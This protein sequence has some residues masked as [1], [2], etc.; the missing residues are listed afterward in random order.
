MKTSGNIT[1]R[2]PATLAVLADVSKLSLYVILN[3]EIMP[4]ELLLKRI[5][6]KCKAKG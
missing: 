3:H 6:V 2:E 5:V 4:K 1:S